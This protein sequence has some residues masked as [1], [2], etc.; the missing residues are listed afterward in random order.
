[1]FGF[2]TPVLEAEHF[3]ET[4]E[5]RDNLIRDKQNAITIAD[6]ADEREIVVWRNEDATTRNHWLH[7]ERS[8]GFG[9][10]Q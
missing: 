2:D 6:L 1:M 10:P 5:A 3:A 8:N 9:W 4:A 7:N